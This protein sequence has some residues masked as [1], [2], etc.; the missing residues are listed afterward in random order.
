LSRDDLGIWL[1]YA[2]LLPIIA[3]GVKIPEEESIAFDV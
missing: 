2:F 3:A 1:W